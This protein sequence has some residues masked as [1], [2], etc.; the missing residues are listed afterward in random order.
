[1]CQCA[2][3]PLSTTIPLPF[4]LCYPEPRHAMCCFAVPGVGWKEVPS[5]LQAKPDL[6]LLYGFS[7]FSSRYLFRDVRSSDLSSK[8]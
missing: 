8:N 6:Y 2:N 4:W 3:V 5:T 1:M 7:T